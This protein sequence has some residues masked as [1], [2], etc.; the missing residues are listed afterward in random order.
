MSAAH[1][2][3]SPAATGLNANQ[4]NNDTEFTPTEKRLATLIAQFAM[5][6]HQVHKLDDGFLV[7]RWGMSRNCPDLASLVGFARHLGVT[8]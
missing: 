2:S 6:G 3:E 7:A 1:K 4:S 5:A 8:K